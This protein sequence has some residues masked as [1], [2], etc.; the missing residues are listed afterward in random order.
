MQLYRNTTDQNEKCFII[1]AF[2]R[3]KDKRAVPLLEKAYKTEIWG[4][5]VLAAEALKKIT[6]KEYKVEEPK[7]SR[8]E[9]GA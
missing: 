6:G 1:E 8:P 4:I 2:G 3:I 9:K 7:E 5:R